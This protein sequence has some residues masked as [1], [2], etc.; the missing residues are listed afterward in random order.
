MSFASGLIW[1]KALSLV[2]S[3]SEQIDNVVFILNLLSCRVCELFEIS[4]H[5][6]EVTKT[7]VDVE[8]KFVG[9]T[10]DLL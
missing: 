3:F 2:N 7:S 10:H 9:N 6:F 5:C 4:P 1:G 8:L